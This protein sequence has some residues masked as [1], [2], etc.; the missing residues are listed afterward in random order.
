MAYLFRI[1]CLIDFIG[2]F[3]VVHAHNQQ[4]SKTIVFFMQDAL[5]LFGNT[6]SGKVSN[7]VKLAVCKYLLKFCQKIL[8]RCA[9]PFKQFLNYVVSFLMPIAKQKE[10]TVTVDEAMKILKF[11][12]V[13]QGAHLKE[14]IAVLDS[15]PSQ[16][17]FEQLAEIH[18]EAKYNGRAFT[19]SDEIEYFL[20]V[21]KRKVEGLLALKEQV[22]IFSFE[23][24]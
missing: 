17:K 14:A 13:E 11:L 3:L 16:P 12:I 19:L 18:R 7:K 5:H 24:F 22:R 1:C 21:D 15:F 2:D 23:Y 4:R 8:P 10:H 9:N 6:I 20:K